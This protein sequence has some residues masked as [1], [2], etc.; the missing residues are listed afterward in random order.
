M[1]D[2]LQSA[3]QGLNSAKHAAKISNIWKC[4]A[5]TYKTMK[6]GKQF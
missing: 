4:V 2:L 5:E 6:V 3:I 1:A